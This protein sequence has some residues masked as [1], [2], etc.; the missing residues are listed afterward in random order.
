MQV[1][2]VLPIP[3]LPIFQSEPA[4]SFH[5]GN[6]AAFLHKLF[7]VFLF[8]FWVFFGGGAFCW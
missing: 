1:V 3:V 8:G 6:S 5:S 7:V 2:S 4:S